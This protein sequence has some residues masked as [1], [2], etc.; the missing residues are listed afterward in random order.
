[1][2][3]QNNFSFN[4][5]IFFFFNNYFIFYFFNFVYKN[6]Y[7][8]FYI[9]LKIKKTYSSVKLKYKLNF[10]DFKNKIYS[11]LQN[12][13]FLLKKTY[14][15]YIF[16][17]LK[18]KKKIKFF[19]IKKFYFSNI[20][21]RQ[22]YKLFFV[23]KNINTKK[24]TKKLNIL[25]KTKNHFFLKKIIF[26]LKYI[27]L[28]NHMLLSKNDLFFFLKKKIVFLNRLNINNPNKILKQND[29]IEFIYFKF[30]FVYLLKIS[31]ILFYKNFFFF[32]FKQK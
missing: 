23:N 12:D 21:N 2:L 11:N 22:L 29:I 31:K 15:F 16:N 7:I 14:F 6:F 28:I 13:N 32:K 8:Y 20:K 10:F 1:M 18:K 4:L 3:I 17:F 5:N 24:I 30:F 9:L 19:E 26:S 27:L 25:N